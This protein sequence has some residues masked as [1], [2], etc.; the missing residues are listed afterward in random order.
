MSATEPTAGDWF[1]SAW[2][3]HAATTVLVADPAA[4]TGKS[5][6]A[7]CESEA[8]A[9]LFAAS[10]DLLAALEEARNGL[11]WY[12]ESYPTATDGSDDEAMARI[13][14]A[15]AKATGSAA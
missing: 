10:K 5:V 3:S 7:E 13:N 11:R 1:V 2:T 15:I 14:A 8:D 12:Q 4:V 9:R 6:I